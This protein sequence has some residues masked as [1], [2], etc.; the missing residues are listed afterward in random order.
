MIVSSDRMS[1]MAPLTPTAGA[2]R[3]QPMPRPADACTGNA[4]LGEPLTGA[5][6]PLAE[7]DLERST[8]ARLCQ[9]G[10]RVIR[11]EGLTWRLTATGGVLV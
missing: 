7:K 8:R 9:K 6:N 1:E 2:I 10:L 11:P 4:Y 3:S 5:I